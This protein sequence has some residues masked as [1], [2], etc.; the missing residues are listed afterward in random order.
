MLFFPR[1]PRTAGNPAPQS[2]CHGPSGIRGDGARRPSAMQRG[3]GAPPRG[4]PVKGSI[5]PAASTFLST[6]SL[7]NDILNLSKHP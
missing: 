6:V 1:I 2:F 3:A 7:Q 5:V 4:I